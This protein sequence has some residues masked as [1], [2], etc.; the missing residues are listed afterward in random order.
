MCVRGIDFAID[1]TIFSIDFWTYFF[2]FYFI[3]KS[4]FIYICTLLDIL[5]IAR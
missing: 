4:N 5:F 2:V 1:S 3:I